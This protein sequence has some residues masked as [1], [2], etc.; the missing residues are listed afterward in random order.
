M[1]FHRAIFWW[2]VNAA[3]LLAAPQASADATSPD[4][5]Q[6]TKA[7][8]DL[9]LKPVLQVA[10]RGGPVL[11]GGEI[12]ADARAKFGAA[13]GL[14]A[15]V[16]LMRH[17]YAGLSAEIMT[18][19]TT[20]QLQMAQDSII[21][22]GMGPMVGWYMRPE[23]LSAVL[24]IGAGG[25]FFSVSN[26]TGRGDSYGSFEGRAM[27]GLTF[28]IGPLRLIVPRLD[29]VGGGGGGAGAGS[30]AHAILTLG[31]SVGYDHD[32]SRKLSD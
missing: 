19:S 20:D 5:E 23:T 16:R 15:G 27:L 14:D 13:F 3:V 29:F 24:E 26:Q 25:R 4:F 12:V 2:G 6:P 8:S 17:V 10:L 28:P 18:F 1:N 21:G 7:K 9:G 31:L 22:F 11:A 30:L 32:F